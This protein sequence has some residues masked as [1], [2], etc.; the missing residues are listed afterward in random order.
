MDGKRLSVVI[1][2]R[3]RARLLGEA[4]A[5]L[6]RQTLPRE[7]Y[8]VIVVDDGSTDATPQ[9]CRA[10]EHDL[11][12]V[13][14]PIPP[15]GIAA[16]KNEGIRAAKG[17]VLF[18]F[19]DDDVAGAEL[20][21]GHLDA[22]LRRPE[23]EVVVL[24]YTSWSPFLPVTPVMEYTTEIGM[25]V[26]SYPL[27]REGRELGFDHF[28]G[29]RSSCKRNFLLERGMFDPGFTWGL[30]DVEL[31]YRL[32]REGLRI[33][34]DP[35]LVSYANRP[36][37][38]DDVC[39]RCEAIGQALISLAT[40][41][42]EPEILRYCRLEN[43]IAG[44]TGRPDEAARLWREAEKDLDERVERARALERRVV[45]RSPIERWRRSH[46]L[47]IRASWRVDP[48]RRALRRL[49]ASTFADF[50]IKGAAEALA[51]H[52]AARASAA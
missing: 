26:F 45:R 36:L 39:R 41:H 38:Y 23:P 6:T 5:S 9:V 2:T 30:E 50:R 25:E 22:H 31:G 10:F 52:E 32:S 42:P 35:R 48:Q 14:L 17:D 46:Q 27:V 21:G 12:L 3:N 8:E 43:P 33:V 7:L 37:D 51:E 15:S 11:D 24:G 47:A 28:W 34:F 4:L 18:F 13:Y 44:R 16:A 19:D 29:G 20:L 40:A 49:Y 1:P